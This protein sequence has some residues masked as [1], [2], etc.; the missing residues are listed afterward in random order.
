MNSSGQPRP[1]RPNPG[2]RD[3]LTELVNVLSV[4]RL[5]PYRH[6][7]G[8]D[9]SAALELYLWNAKVSSAYFESLHLVEV[10]LRNRLHDALHT[11]AATLSVPGNN[12]PC[13]WYD[14]PGIRLQ[15]PTRDKVAE[16]RQRVPSPERPGRVVAELSLGFWRALL[17]DAYNTTLWAPCLKNAF[18]GPVR[19]RRL[20]HSLG[21][22][23]TL[24]NRIAHHEPIH[25]RELAADYDVTL[26]VAARISPA[27]ARWI[28]ATSRIPGLLDARPTRTIRA[29]PPEPS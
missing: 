14:H 26:E 5:A 2:E 7:C 3:D 9:T 6:A 15:Q 10:G 23:L 29:R 28:A 25:A 19:R 24:R 20:H 16:A 8:G 1:R 12:R 18:P 13:S 11:W 21:H 27:L 17:A 4:E 22:L